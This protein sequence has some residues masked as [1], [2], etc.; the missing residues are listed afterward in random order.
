MGW[1]GDN[2]GVSR[3]LAEVNLAAVVNNVL[4]LKSAA[5]DSQLLAV[6]KADGY[7]HGMIP[8]ARAA[9]SAGADYLGVAMPEEAIAVRESGDG[10][11]L[12]CWLYAPSDD[13][14][15]LVDRNV[16]LSVSSVESL[17]Q[18]VAAAR[19]VDRVARVHLK[20]DT[21]LGRNGATP[22]DWE[23]LVAGSL[24]RQ[25]Q[26]VIEIVGIWSHLACSDEPQSPVTGQQV[27]AFQTALAQADSL[28]LVPRLRH[29]ANSGGTLWHPDTHFDMVRCG[30]SVYGLS[31]GAAVG[32]S[33]ALGL[34]PAMNVTAQVAMVKRVPGG[35]GVSYGLRYRTR[36]ATQLAL[37]PVGYADGL[38]R[39]GSGRLPVMIAGKRFTVAGTVAMDQVVIDIGDTRVRAG[40]QVQLF[41]SGSHGEPT[42]DDWAEA[43]G[44]IN[45]EIVTRLGPRLPR[46]HLSGA[47]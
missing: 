23:A 29:L 1:A 9:R 21:G 41:G 31:P 40:D 43:C 47:A 44:T 45:Y 22:A 25:G 18:V 10:G 20:I 3:A 6:V 8:V 19:R 15:E 4:T 37:V 26:G 42:A 14:A 16:D 2:R 28:G 30:I 34:I 11:P 13:L 39:S 35:H 5:P 7:G 46:R 17:E 36:R 38:P 27:E 32:S 24:V 12:L 33:A